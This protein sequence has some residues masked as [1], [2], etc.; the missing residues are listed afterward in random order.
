MPETNLG[1]TKDSANW[2]RRTKAVRA[3]T[4]RS[5]FGETSEA[6]FLTSGY[7]YPN[8]E[9]AEARFKGKA[10]GFIY[11]RF[12]NP[13]VGMFEERIAELEG[14]ERAMATATGM[15]AVNASLLCQVKTGDHVV[16]SRA[17]F[18]SCRYVIE[19][20]LPRFG[21]DITMV[22]GTDLDQWRD[23]VRPETVC[24][25]LETPSNPML[26]IIDLQEVADIVHSVEANVIVDNAFATPALQR[27]VETGADI[28]VYSATKHIDGQG[29]CLGGAVLATNE[30]IEDTLKPFLRHTGPALSPFNAWVMLKGLETLD[31]RVEQH[32]RNAEGVADF[33][34]G[35]DKIE[36]VLYPGLDS[37][38]QHKLAMAQMDAGGGLVTF[39]LGGG[40]E[41]A[42][43]FLNALKIVDI[44]NN[45]GD[46]KSLITHPATTT[47][48][49]LD[50]TERSHLGIYAGTVRL[51]VGLEDPEDIKE[52]LAQAFA[53]AAA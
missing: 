10:D 5:E 35:Q 41:A 46:T 21:V 38:P 33:L 2:R 42:F 16:A 19:E 50:E 29:R 26:E 30:F 27:P 18:G 14:A 20:I 7:A 40:K 17:L 13:T 36:R 28:V 47:H 34:L 39:D 52:D 24:A 6:I 12:S 11:S 45:L 43:R 37:H 1:T 48:Q 53:R 8:A 22:D 4:R 15:A 49:R 51:S 32:C 44:S 23:A 31:L 9:E 3:G 25:F